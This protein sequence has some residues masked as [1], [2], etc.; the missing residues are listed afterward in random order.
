MKRTLRLLAAAVIGLT[1]MACASMEKMQK[2]A[3]SVRITCEP[4]VLEIVA[5]EIDAD[6]TVTVRRSYKR[7]RFGNAV[8]E[9]LA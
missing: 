2:M 5:G 7:R 9:Q 3:D 1:A 6:V 8:V 4:A